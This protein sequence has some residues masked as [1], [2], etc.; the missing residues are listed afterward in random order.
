MAC[1]RK[2]LRIFWP[3]Q[4]TNNE[5]WKR[6]ER[7]RIDLQIRKRKWGWL[8]NTQRKPS[9]GIARQFLGWNPK[10]NGAEGD[11]GTHGEELC[12]KRP[13]ELKRPGQRLNV[14]PRT[15]C[16]GGFLWKPYVP[17]RNDSILYIYIY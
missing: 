13:K 5:L 9:D 8:G 16:D 14:M 17:R 1:L 10:A 6:T 7:P 2:I 3:D 11:R 4:I 15:E 12:L